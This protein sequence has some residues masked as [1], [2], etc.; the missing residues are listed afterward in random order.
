MVNSDGIIVFRSDGAVLA[1]RAFLKLPPRNGIAA[2]GGA[3]R[4]TF[5]A[6]KAN[7]RKV[8]EAALFRSHD[9]QTEFWEK[10]NEQE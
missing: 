5:E 1:Y 4:R 2:T 3:R 9:G 7:L 10:R 8:P 6:L